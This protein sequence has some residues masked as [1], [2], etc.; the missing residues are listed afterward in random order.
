MLAA[1][2]FMYVKAGDYSIAASSGCR[3]PG[4]AALIFVAF[5]APSP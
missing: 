3:S 1:L 4:G 2:I 5:L